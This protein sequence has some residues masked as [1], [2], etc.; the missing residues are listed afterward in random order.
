VR[1]PS[2]SAFNRGGVKK[3]EQAGT[4]G[5]YTIERRDARAKV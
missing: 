2:L 1:G 3:I 4:L 5:I